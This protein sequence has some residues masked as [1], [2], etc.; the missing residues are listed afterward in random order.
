M[1]TDSES[2]PVLCSTPKKS[3]P[4]EHVSLRQSIDLSYDY[5][6]IQLLSEV[7]DYGSLYTVSKSIYKPEHSPSDIEY[8]VFV[9]PDSSIEALVSDSLRDTL[10]SDSLASGDLPFTSP[11]CTVW[12]PTSRPS[13]ACSA[14]TVIA[15]APTTNKEKYLR[16]YRSNLMVWEDLYEDLDLALLLP[17]QLPVYQTE[18]AQFMSSIREMQ[19]YFDESPCDEYDQACSD[20]SCDL[21]KRAAV[22]HKQLQTKMYQ[23]QL[24][25]DQEAKRQ[26]DADALAAR[27]T[28][29]AAA[30]ANPG[31]RRKL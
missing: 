17:D 6:G 11:N 10:H 2:E 22:I 9:S 4:T 21:R 12:V 28:A 18:V 1:S 8:D 16:I 24:K 14:A 13:T 19:L 15:M 25:K 23:L 7:E 3:K 20:R 5:D 29:D 30:A 31:G 26:A 27:T